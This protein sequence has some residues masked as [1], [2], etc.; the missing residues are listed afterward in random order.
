MV[1]TSLLLLCTIFFNSGRAHLES[2]AFPSLYDNVGHWQRTDWEFP[3]Y[4]FNSACIEV[5]NNY[6]DNSSKKKFYMQWICLGGTTNNGSNHEYMNSIYEMTFE[7]DKTA[8]NDAVFQN[9][10]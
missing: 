3:N 5:W 2:N 4:I 1:W 6:N 10:R 8:N 9:N 7:F